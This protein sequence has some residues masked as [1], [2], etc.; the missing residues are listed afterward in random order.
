MIKLYLIA[1]LSFFFITDSQAGV[2]SIIASTNSSESESSENSYTSSDELSYEIDPQSCPQA[3]Y[4][5]HGCPSGYIPVGE[6]PYDSSY[7][8]G[9]CQEQ[10]QYR[11]E[12][13][14]AAGMQPSQTT[15]HGYHA[16]EPINT[17]Q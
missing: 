16:C 12:D 14:I 9:C 11:A 4:T 1:A 13:C 7:Y 3:G 17:P 10:Y 15:C 8:M 5:R 6:C 2:R